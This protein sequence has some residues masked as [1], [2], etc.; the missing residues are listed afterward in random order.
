MRILLIGNGG[1]E[2]A[3]AWKLASSPL[4]ET[5]FIAPGNPGTES[6]GTNVDIPATDIARLV[7]FARREAIDLTVVG[8]EQPLVMGIVDAFEDAGLVIFG[9]TAAAARLEGSKAF[10][11]AFME[12]HRIPTAAHRTF[13]AAAYAEADAYLET[14]EMPVV[15]KASGLAAGKGVIICTTREEARGALRDIVR[16][17]RFGDA[18]DEVVIEAFMQGEEA[19]LFAVS[20][21]DH[22]VLL[23]TAQ[24]HKRVGDGDTGPNTGGMGA[25]AP[26]PIVTP[27]LEARIRQDIIEPTLAGMRKEGAPFRGFLYVGLMI[28]EGRARVVEYNCRLGDPEAQV[29]LPLLDADFAALIRAATEGDVRRVPTPNAA[30]AAACV[31]MASAGYPGDYPK[32]LPIAGLDA[33]GQLADALIFHAGTKRD[34]DGRIV[35]AGGRV[36][37]VTGAGPSLEDALRRAYA[38][39]KKIHFEGAHYRTDIGKKG[40]DRRA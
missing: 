12:R 22:Y 4:C 15:L 35:T 40:L 26:A 17:H 2:H 29:I 34:A 16:D 28:D 19:S 31:I 7:A 18:G 33:G 38:G 25:Y 1:R 11:K 23:A 8:P 24:D 20:D 36:L 10:A 21:G 14:A 27:A 30:G 3:M 13:A 37:A 6:V 39:V 5:L 32:H 9:P